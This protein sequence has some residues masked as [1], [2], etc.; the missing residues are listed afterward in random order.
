[1]SEYN[2]QQGP[3]KTPETPDP[4][5]PPAPP[6]ATFD[7][8]TGEY[9]GGKSS[10]YPTLPPA[11]LEPS[12]VPP[13]PQPPT[14]PMNPSAYPTQPLQPPLYDS[15]TGERLRDEG[16]P[17]DP[18]QPGVAEQETRPPHES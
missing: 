18:T 6:D 16:S 10:E 15:Q 14:Q 1:M 5:L 17:E 2:D 13:A 3:P 8:S 7:P 12:T 11:T 4:S 9:R